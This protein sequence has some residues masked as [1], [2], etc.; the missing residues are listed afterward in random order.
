MIFVGGLALLAG[1][2]FT[3]VAGGW[4]GVDVLGYGIGRPWS[5]GG[6]PGY[7]TPWRSLTTMRIQFGLVG[8]IFLGFGLLALWC[9][10]SRGGSR[11]RA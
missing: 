8:V 7:G 1:S 10:D 3:A 2:V 4:R 5:P 11:R 6:G 9:A